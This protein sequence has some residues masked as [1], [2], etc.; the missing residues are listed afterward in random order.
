MKA[1]YIFIRG[2]NI[3]F[4]WL[5]STLMRDIDVAILSVGLSVRNIP[6]LD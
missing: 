2:Q 6:V 1:S 5:V 4:L 3:K